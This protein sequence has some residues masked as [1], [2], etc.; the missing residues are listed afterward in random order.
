MADG[1]L[2]HYRYYPTVVDLDNSEIELY[3]ELTERI[4]RSVGPEE[5][6]E[7]LSDAVKMLLIKRAR[8]VA[9]ARDK[10]PRLRALLAARRSDTHILVYCGD[11]SV[12]GQEDGTVIRQIDEAV[13][14]IGSDV[15]MRCARY[16]A[17]TSP[18]RRQDLLEQFA[19]GEIQVLVAI[20]CLDEGIDIPAARTALIL[21]S[22][23]NPRQSVQRR[24]RLLRLDEGK[25]RA[26]IF[27]FFVTFP[28]SSYSEIHPSFQIARRL[29]RRQLLR[30]SEF[31]SLADNGPSARNELLELRSHFGLLSEG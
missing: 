31:A 25:S 17:D 1:V 29:I 2:T 28:R 10:L 16:T 26:D 13:K 11:G 24:G 4:M 19:G 15:G 3:T 8:L 18:Q 5:E 22:S 7:V 6:S 9:T 30:V 14:L 27:D 12:E 21:A 23:A 20:R